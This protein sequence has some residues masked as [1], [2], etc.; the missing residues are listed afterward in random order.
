MELWE[1]EDWVLEWC[2][3]NNYYLKEIKVTNKSL[4]IRMYYKTHSRFGLDKLVHEC[5]HCYFN[6][7][8]TLK[9]VPHGL[10]GKV[11]DRKFKQ[12]KS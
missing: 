9:N 6:D 12:T 4:E 2:H 1:F 7:D 5:Y 11:R 8:M 10:K 3:K